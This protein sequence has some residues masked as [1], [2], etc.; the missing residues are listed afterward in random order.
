M[1][2]LVITLSKTFP[3]QHPKAGQPT[4]F[5]EKITAF[6]GNAYKKIHTC[7]Q[8]VEYWAKKIDKLKAD[9]GVLSVRQWSGTPRRSKQEIIVNIPAEDIGYSI[10]EWYLHDR[11]GCTNWKYI[12]VWEMENGHK[13]SCRD[14]TLEELASN[15][16][17]SV[18]DF[19]AWF[20]DYDLT[21]PLIMI[22]FTNFKY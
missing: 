13:K 8:N 6:K 4:Y 19:K 7:R 3:R 21:K 17:L 1:K 15:D 14:I 10:I 5:E 9:G 16:G 11:D 22:H 12:R 18:D 20:R 2:T